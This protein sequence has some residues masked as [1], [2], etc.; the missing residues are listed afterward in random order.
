MPTIAVFCGS[1]PG[2]DPR[3]QQAAQEL[4]RGIG[5]RGWGMVFGGGKIGLMGEVARA[6]FQHGGQVI[7]VIP[8]F[9][10]ALEIPA[11]E[12][13]ELIRVPDMHTRK[14]IMAQRADAFVVLPGGYGTCDELFEILTW[15]Q[16]GLHDKPIYLVNVAEFFDPL[17]ALA[18]HMQTHGFL[19]PEYRQMLR[20]ETTAEAVLQA[21][22]VVE[23]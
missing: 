3:F 19:K 23:Q 4:G 6:T 18:D 7:G 11:E 1:R 5:Q 16:I 21:L 12:C 15:R 2:H 14:A 17:L 20:S 22:A 9:M 13:Q 8:R 10:E